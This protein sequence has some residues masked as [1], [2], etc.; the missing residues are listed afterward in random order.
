[1]R[2]FIRSRATRGICYTLIVALLSTL[3]PITITQP[4]QAQLLPQYTVG[5]VDF[6]NESGVQGD[7][8]ARLATDAVVVEMSKTN[9]YD[10]TMITRS[11][12]KTEMEKLDL[13][14]PLDKLGLVR[15]GEALNADAML[16]GSIRSVQLAGSGATRRASATLVI[17]MI[18][19][20][21]GEIINGAVQ[22]GTSAARVGYTAD[23]DALITEAINSAAFLCVKTMVDYIIPEATV[24]MNIGND[25][26]MLNKGVRDGLKP[27][28]QMIVLR[29]KEII[30]YIEVRSV[31]ASDAIAKVI[32]S[33]RGIQPEDKVRAIF[34]MPMATSALKSE[35]LPSG[36]PTR[37]GAKGNA[38][39]KIGKFILGAAIVFG[40]VSLF[41]GGAGTEDALPAGSIQDAGAPIITWPTSELPSPRTSILELQVIR[42]TFS[43]ET[44]PVAVIRD[45]SQMNL[46]FVKLTGI[47]GAAA[48]KPVSYYTVDN[49]TPTAFTEASWTVPAE[50]F[51]TT[52]NYAIRYI[53]KQVTSTSTGTKTTYSYNQ[54]SNMV[55]ATAIERVRNA[56]VVP[57]NDPYNPPTIYTGE[58]LKPGGADNLAW[59]RKEGADQYYVVADPVIPGRGPHYQSPTIYALSNEIGLPD[60]E[61]QALAALLSANPNFADQVMKWKVYCRNS[62]DT[63]QQWIEGQ[64][65][66][67]II[68]LTPPGTP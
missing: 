4:A 68:G 3:A 58:L 67:F 14:P 64:E 55:I 50:P 35:P 42:D 13:R 29:A 7:M 61:R 30:G 31:D 36:A 15:L 34:Q 18:D 11:L 25:Q 12:I 39:S 9:R 2:Q 57:V 23:D 6:A 52:H 49:Q 10:V 16:Q 32:K 41:K 5:V 56:D 37:G 40:L 65:N 59:Q 19:Q 53:Y 21:S 62:A 63:S 66:R 27:G 51:G 47:Y 44:A 22:T 38:G 54:L 24:M 28:M 48:G 43:N 8:L 26:I 20:S 60:A 33:M 46:G 1:L 45:V 17:Q